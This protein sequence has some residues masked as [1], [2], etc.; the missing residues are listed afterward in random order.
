MLNTGLKVITD[1]F[2]D[3]GVNA[4]SGL[5]DRI[6]PV[7]PVSAARPGEAGQMLN[8]GLKVITDSF[9]DSGASALSGLRDRIRPVAPVSAAR[10]GTVIN[11]R[12]R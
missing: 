1:S 6:R 3:S 12:H 2:P 9:P 4:L 5:R 7:A 11:V 10:P 8:T